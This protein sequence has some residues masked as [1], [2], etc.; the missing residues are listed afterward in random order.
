VSEILQRRTYKPGD[1]IFKEGEHGSHAYVIQEGEVEI[2]KEIDG[3]IR[4]L[5][6]IGKGGMFGEMALIDAK[7]RMAMARAKKGSTIIMVTQQMFDQKM[8]KA[9][10]FIRGLLN[11]LADH[12]RSASK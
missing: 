5:G 4:I 1:V 3:E 11:I 8:S 2:S 7:P 12:V 10:P 9:D 6:V